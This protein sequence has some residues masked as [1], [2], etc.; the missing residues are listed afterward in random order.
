MEGMTQLRCKSKP[1]STRWTT[2]RALKR[3]GEFPVARFGQ[4]V[5][6]F[7]NIRHF[8]RS[9]D[10]IS[11][12][13]CKKMASKGEPGPSK[14]N[15]PHPHPS[16]V[17]LWKSRLLVLILDIHDSSHYATEDLGR[18]ETSAAAGVQVTHPT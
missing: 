11:Y 8:P 17:P 7:R 4:G 2:A 14:G 16:A 15:A 13:I 1:G 18:L 12:A 9:A 3:K 10:S 5:T 6:V